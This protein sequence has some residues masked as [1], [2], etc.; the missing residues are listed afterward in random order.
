MYRYEI[1]LVSEKNNSYRSFNIE[2]LETTRIF[3]NIHISPFALSVLLFT[4]IHSM[5][6]ELGRQLTR[7]ATKTAG[8]QEVL[9]LIAARADINYQDHV[10]ATPLIRAALNGRIA[11]LNILI[12]AGADI[13]YCSSNSRQSALIAATRGCISS[14][15]P[16]DEYIECVQA[17]LKAQA[18][19]LVTDA[20]GQTPLI[21]ASY[22]G[23]PAIAEILVEELLYIPNKMHKQKIIITFI[24]CRTKRT[25]GLNYLR[26]MPKDIARLIGKYIHATYKLE[27]Q[28]RFEDSE[29]FNE[30]EK[31][32]EKNRIKIKKH[33]IA[34]YSSKS[35]CV[36]Q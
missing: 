1:F 14:C 2:K 27:D 3:M 6:D 5:D 8:T 33:L 19:I 18:N 35:H 7:A 25:P 15:K 36:V 17:L 9:Q 30:V 28:I 23:S 20:W 13:N 26:Q 4:S 31:I 12:E 34:K 11:S 29:A 22:D 10:Q 32:P 24:G 16:E 21:Y